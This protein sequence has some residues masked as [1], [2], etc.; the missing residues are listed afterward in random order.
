MLVLMDTKQPLTLERRQPHL[1][2]DGKGL[3]NRA[4]FGEDHKG[5]S[6]EQLTAQLPRELPKQA[7]HPISADGSPNRFPT[8]IP[9]RLPLTSVRQITILNRAVEIRLPCSL[10]YSMSRLR[11]RN[12]SL[13]PPPC[14]IVI[15]IE[16]G[17]LAQDFP[18]EPR[19]PDSVLTRYRHP[20]LG[21]TL[22]GA[23]NGGQRFLRAALVSVARPIR[24]SGPA[25]LRDDEPRPSGHSSYSSAYGI[26]VHVFS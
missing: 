16:E 26:H 24:L 14:D 2:Q 19:S 21:A 25:P 4:P 17:Q 10:A 3:H 8:T 22:P 1:F 15:I 13:S 7:L 12:R 11:F 23:H 9:T 20:V 6:R 18:F 5:Q